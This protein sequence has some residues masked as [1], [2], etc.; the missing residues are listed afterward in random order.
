MRT[1]PAAL[2]GHEPSSDASIKPEHVVLLTFLKTSCSSFPPSFHA[3]LQASWLLLQ[4]LV[5]KHSLPNSIILVT[6]Q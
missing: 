1:V 2:D 5:S 3:Y 6:P 4:P